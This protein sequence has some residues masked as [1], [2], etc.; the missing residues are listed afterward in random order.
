MRLS[1]ALH[2]IVGGKVDDTSSSTAKSSMPLDAVIVI[3]G[4]Q[5]ENHPIGVMNAEV[6]RYRRRDDDGHDDDFR[7]W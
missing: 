3:K 2:S 5:G 7:I 4:G 6:R 1:E